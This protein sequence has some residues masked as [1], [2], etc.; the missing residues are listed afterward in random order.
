MSAITGYDQ[1][2]QYFGSY[3]VFAPDNDAF[4][5]YFQNHPAYNSVED[6]PLEELM[7]NCKIPYCSE[8][9]EYR[10]AQTAGCLWLDRFTDLNNDEP[11]GF[12]RETLLREK[13]RNYGVDNS[14]ESSE[15]RES[16]HCGY[17]TIC[18]VQKTGIPIHGNMLLYSLMNILIFMT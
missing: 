4:D 14:S 6:I 12:K 8:S 18:M 5:L 16:D 11:R 17:L 10:A 7:K 3:T 2:Y 1:Y 13:N 15:V 9:L